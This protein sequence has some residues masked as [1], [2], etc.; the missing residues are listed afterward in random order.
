MS[1]PDNFQD[2]NT[3][4]LRNKNAEKKG[5]NGI[6]E[7][8]KRN[9]G[10]QKPSDEKLEI[11]QEMITTDL[12][13]KIIQTRIALKLTQDKLATSINIKPTDIKLL[14]S[15]KCTL[16]DAKQICIKIERKYRVKILENS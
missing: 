6:T 15:G 1:N 9:V 5:K 14:E 13:Q 11:P 10:D 7:V 3:V 4:I 8:H 2:W 16:K 12:K